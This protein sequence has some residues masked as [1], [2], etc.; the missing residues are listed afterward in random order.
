MR[1]LRRN[2]RRSSSCLAR[3]VGGV[4][5]R[6]DEL[7]QLAVGKAGQDMSKAYQCREEGHNAGI[8][9]AETGCTLPVGG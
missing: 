6:H 2:R 4:K 1:P 5:Q 7:N 9:E 8:A 3:G